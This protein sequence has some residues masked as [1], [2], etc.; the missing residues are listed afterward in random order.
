MTYEFTVTQK[1]T[2]LHIII[3]GQLSKENVMQ[4]FEEIHLIPNSNGEFFLK[5]VCK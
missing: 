2:Y 4:Y 1:S 5:K 3:T